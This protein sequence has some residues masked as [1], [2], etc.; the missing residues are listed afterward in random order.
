MVL[1]DAT[2][3]TTKYSLP[4]FQMCIKTNS[5]YKIVASFVIENETVA[6]IT[7]AL[8]IIKAWNPEWCYKYFMTDYDREEI[9]A[10]ESTF[11]GKIYATVLI[12][13]EISSKIIWLNVML[14]DA[15]AAIPP[16]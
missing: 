6:L 12:S 9:A 14:D 10:L 2:Y 7:E 1:V 16:T 11:P 13:N 4:I 8:Q 15:F 3:K 5:G